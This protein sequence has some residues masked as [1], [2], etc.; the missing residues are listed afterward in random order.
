MKKISVLLLAVL[1]LGLTMV[2]CT[3]D[4]VQASVEGKWSYDSATGTVNGVAIGDIPGGYIGQVNTPGCTKNTIELKTGGVI[5]GL[6]Y[7]GTNCTV[8]KGAGTWT[9]DG[10]NLS[11]V[12]N[13]E[14][15]NYTI[16]SVTDTTLKIK[17]TQTISGSVITLTA[18]FI[19][20]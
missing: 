19:K 8:T 2:S 4:D 12:I 13:G 15:Q 3:K 11:F 7:A 20:A 9:K 16:E 17:T 6:T 5:E 1:T 14:T 18:T 10:D